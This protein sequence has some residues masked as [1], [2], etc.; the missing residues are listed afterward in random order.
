M[1]PAG[2]YFQ[3]ITAFLFVAGLHLYFYTHLSESRRD[4]GWPSIVMRNWHECG[5]AALHGQ[6]VAN[7]G[8]LETGEAQFIYPGHRPTFLLAPYFLKELPGAAFGDGALYDFTVLAATFAAMLALFGN[9]WRG[10]FFGAVV[11]F[12]PGFI[13]NVA[14]IDT[15]NVPALFS[16]SALGFAAAVFA[17]RESSLILQAIALAVTLLFMLMNWSTLFPL[18][19][20]TA[21]IFCKC[22]WK[23]AAVFFAP[24]LLIG[25]VILFISM[26][27][28]SSGVG[29]T[30]S[31]FCNAYLFGPL[32][33]DHGGMTWGKAIVR[34]TAVN[35]IAWFS[36][37][38]AGVTA[39]WL[40]GRAA[41]WKT[42][43]LPLLAG[44]IAVFA[45]RNYNAHHPWNAVCY[46]GLGLLFSFELLVVD[47]PKSNSRRGQFAITA[48][49]VFVFAYAVAWMALDDFNTRGQQTLR[50]LVVKN[51]P[52]HALVLVADDFLPTGPADLKN[53]TKMFDRKLAPLGNWRREKNGR[54]VFVL[55]HGSLP[56]GASPVAQ[57]HVAPKNSDKII[58]GLFDFYR[59]KIA[60]RT[61]G[62]RRSYF[63]DY[64]LGKF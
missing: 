27:S 51:T 64:Q 26:H 7:P 32:G 49:S 57:S 3:P 15:I 41:K 4:D 52:R 10:I 56:D 50:D 12:T 20:A 42:S 61:P 5:Y 55:V 19:I 33:Y 44:I 53:F 16:L 39:V 6:L 21:Y 9:N 40:N 46:I 45:L 34:I 30:T 60:R 22:G 14:A 13:N 23:P 25:M 17:R 38:V 28:K 54:E 31:D 18:G 43:F 8:G 36:L 11:C 48:V 35:F 63:D 59:E 37:I 1:F 29:A 47:E 2:K 58:A 62:I 24:A